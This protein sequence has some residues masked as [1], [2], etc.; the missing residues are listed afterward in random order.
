[1]FS[2]L[3]VAIA[4]V[5]SKAVQIL[6]DAGVNLEHRDNL[7]YSALHHV[8]AGVDAGVTDE[9]SQALKIVSNLLTAGADVWAV[10]HNSFTPLPIHSAL[11]GLKGFPGIAERLLEVMLAT[12]DQ[13]TIGNWKSK[14]L[15]FALEKVWRQCPWSS[16]NSS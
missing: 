14:I 16:A 7:D 5:D 3:R 13:A 12:A 10:A 15:H 4:E 9:D 1:M 6:L 11:R 2:A 8:A